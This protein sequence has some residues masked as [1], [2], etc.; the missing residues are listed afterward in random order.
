MNIT[1]V[2][3]HVKGH[4]ERKRVGRGPSSGLGKTA[5]RGAKGMKARSGPT[6]MIRR[7]GGQMPI[8]RRI[9]KRGF[10]NNVFRVEYAP[11]NLLVLEKN[12]AAKETVTAEALYEKG[13]V[14]KGA[15]VKIL[16]FG[17]LSKALTVKAHAFSKSAQ[18]K[19][20]KSGGAAE[21]IK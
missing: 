14:Q 11:I 13:L 3:A 12:F 9:P 15:P 4:K 6:S 10:N 18:E 2:H 19:I 5:G 20:A 1:E 8:T 16:G 7:E 21:V 17:E